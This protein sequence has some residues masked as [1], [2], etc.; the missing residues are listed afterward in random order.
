MIIAAYDNEP[1]AHFIPSEVLL[2][3]VGAAVPGSTG[4][5]PADFVPSNV[6][7]PAASML[8][9]SGVSVQCQPHNDKTAKS[10]NDIV[11]E[12]RQRMLWPKTP[13]TLTTAHRK[14][15]EVRLAQVS[16]VTEKV[17]RA[18]GI[19]Y[20]YTNDAA[21]ARQFMRFVSLARL[22]RTCRADPCVLEIPYLTRTSCS[23][24][25]FIP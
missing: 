16:P 20:S 25:F 12:E 2:R 5:A 17:R 1:Y 13:L 23:H 4:I 18:L 3:D 8:Q 10:L 24:V 7:L 19:W 15:V 6:D 22:W 21:R 14:Q 11:L 9:P